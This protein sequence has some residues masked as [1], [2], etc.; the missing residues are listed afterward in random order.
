MLAYELITEEVPSLKPTDTGKKV[1]DWMEDFRISHLPVVN[2]R[3]FLGLVSYTDLLDLN[4]TKKTID[5]LRVSM[6]KAF[7]REDYH[8][9]DVLK[10]IS[11]YNVSAVAVLDAD[12]NYMGVITADSIIQK[13][14]NMPFVHEPG[15]IVILELN[16]KDYSL[17]QIAQL[18]EGNDAKILNMHIN[19]H[20]DSTKI[21]VTLKINK[22]DL[23]PILQTFNRYNYTV[24]ATFHQNNFNDDLKK[25]YDEFIHF[26]N[27]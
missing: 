27:I 19:A 22:E 4:N 23:S 7:V 12:N 2:K 11:N 20:H 26:L 16:T 13:I 17:S 24:K 15:S 6:I 8:I 14:A 10:V 18:V 25:R 3:E 21:E 9:F 1:L 5:H